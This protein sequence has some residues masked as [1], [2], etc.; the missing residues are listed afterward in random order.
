M[1]ARKYP[2]VARESAKGLKQPPPPPSAAESSAYLG[3]YLPAPAS[4]TVREIVADARAHG[5]AVDEVV[6]AETVGLWEET[7]GGGAQAGSGAK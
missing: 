3:E 7:G 6:E 4:S 1:V 5:E 2:D